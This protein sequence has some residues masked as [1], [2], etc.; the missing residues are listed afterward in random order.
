[1]RRSRSDR[2]ETV[3]PVGQ[4]GSNGRELRQHSGGDVGRL[5]SVDHVALDGDIEFPI[6]A[7]QH[8]VL[9]SR[10][11]PRNLSERNGASLVVAHDHIANRIETVPFEL[12]TSDLNI[13][14]AIVASHLGHS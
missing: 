10:F 6:V 5:N 8:G 1:M 13:D 14:G 12:R 2:L 3:A 4:A 7:L 9:H 11:D